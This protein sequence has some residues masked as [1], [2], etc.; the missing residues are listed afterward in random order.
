[1]FK[2]FCLLILPI[3][4]CIIVFVSFLYDGNTMKKSDAADGNTIKKSHSVRT[5]KAKNTLIDSYPLIA[6]GEMAAS[7][8]LSKPGRYTGR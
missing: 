1:M 4:G 2:K 5:I 7:P 3:V 8:Y 6:E